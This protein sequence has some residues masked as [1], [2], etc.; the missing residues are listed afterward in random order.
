M[1]FGSCSL[2]DIL[3]RQSE[4]SIFGIFTSRKQPINENA[5]NKQASAANET[6]ADP[7]GRRIQPSGLNRC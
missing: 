6:H 3:S 5:L 2:G 4:H 7:T 1:S